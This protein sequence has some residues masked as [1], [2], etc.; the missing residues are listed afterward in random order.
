MTSFFKTTRFVLLCLGL[1]LFLGACKYEELAAADYPQQILYLPTAK[2]GVF[3][4]ASLPA[5]G[6]VYRFTVKLAEKKVIVPLSV[7]R[8]GVSVDGEVPVTVVANA[9]TVSKMIAASKLLNTEALPTSKFTLPAS[10]TIPTGGESAPF[11]LSIDLDY[12]LANPGKK[13]AVGVSIASPQTPVNPLLNTTV[14][15]IDPAIFKPTTDF[16]SKADATTPRKITFT[17]TSLNALSYS[18]NFGDGSIPSSEKAPS[19]TYTNAGT[20]TVTLTATGITGSTDA[21]KKT[22]TLTIL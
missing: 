10:V 11:E 13:L 14:I 17:N 12:L 15:S 20:Y 1:C 9:D 2:N 3:A 7:F 16:T 5:P 22:A 4:I 21:V 18:W 19:Y 8:G 6:V